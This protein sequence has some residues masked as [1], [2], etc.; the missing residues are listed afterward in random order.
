MGK[1]PRVKWTGRGHL[2]LT[3]ESGYT[4]LFPDEIVAV[5][6]LIVDEHD[7]YEANGNR[8]PNIK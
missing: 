5:A 3:V 8:P 6:N 2:R 1:T 7:K 4:F